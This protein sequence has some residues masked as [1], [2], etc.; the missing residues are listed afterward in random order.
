VIRAVIKRIDDKVENR[1][2]EHG[3]IS[4]IKREKKREEENVR[5]M[6]G[7]Y[8]APLINTK[9]NQK[10]ILKLPVEDRLI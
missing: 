1:L 5:E 2:L 8:F 4:K 10:D 9:R 7:A 6:D 3:E